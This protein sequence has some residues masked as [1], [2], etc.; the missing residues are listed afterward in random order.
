V[1][2]RYV[3]NDAVGGLQRLTHA[4][5]VA[6]WIGNLARLWCWSGEERPKAIP[7]AEFAGS[8]GGTLILMTTRE[9]IGCSKRAFD[10]SGFIPALVRCRHILRDVPLAS[11]FIQI[12]ALITPLFF[13]VV[14]DKVLVHQGLTTLEVLAVGLLV[15]SVFDV[16]IGACAL[17]YSRTPCPWVSWWPSTCWRAMLRAPFCAWRSWPRT[18]NKPASA[19]DRL[20]DILNAPAEPPRSSWR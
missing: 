17:I 10:V 4:V 7:R 15:V 20:G 13:Q 11:L 12:L 5:V 1:P 19:V 8:F 14:I 18:S 9:R 6:Q 2:A 3:D 16:A